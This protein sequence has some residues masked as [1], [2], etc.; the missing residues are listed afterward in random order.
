[1]EATA[2]PQP[3]K[4]L[5]IVG[6]ILGIL[7]C[8]ML[9]ISASMKFLKPPDMQ[10]SLDHVGWRMDQATALGI[11]EVSV[12]IIYLIPR[13]ATLGAILIAAF[14]GGAVATHARVGDVFVI[15]ILIGVLVWLGLWLRDPRLHALL[16]LR[17]P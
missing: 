2:N 11:V 17:R 12:A 15:Q 14:M 7:P 13:T 3:S 6:W 9:F 8:L 16:P 4:A 10:Q 1:M 5:K